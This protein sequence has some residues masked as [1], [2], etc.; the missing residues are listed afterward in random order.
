MLG[1]LR[2]ALDLLRVPEEVE[3][4][5][6]RSA[7]AWERYRETHADRVDTTDEARRAQTEEDRTDTVLIHQSLAYHEPVMAFGILGNHLAVE[8]DASLVCLLPNRLDRGATRAVSSYYYDDV[9]FLDAARWR[10]HRIARALADAIELYR[11]LDNVPDLQG[12][13]YRGIEIGDLVY[14]TALRRT[15]EGTLESI[16]AG[17]FRYVFSAVRWLRCFEAVFDAHRPLALVTGDVKYTPSGV[18]A[19]LAVARD[20]D[21]FVPLSGMG[22]ARLQTLEDLRR[23]RM[24]AR[25]ETF[26][27]LFAERRSALVSRGEAYRRDRMADELTDADAHL[28][29][30]SE[31]ERLEPAALYE[32][33]NLDPANPTVAVMSHVFIDAPV[34]GTYNLFDDYLDWLRRTLAFSVDTPTVN[35][36]VKEHPATERYG[37]NQ[38]ASAEVE[39]ATAGREATTVY[40][41][42][43]HVH[44]ASVADFADAVVTVRGTAGLEFAS[45]GIPPILAGDSRYSG[46][47][48]THEPATRP[49][50]FERLSAVDELEALTAEQRERATSLLYLERVLMSPSSDLVPDWRTYDDQLAV[51]ADAGDRIAGID[52]REDGAYP[53]LE[54]FIRS[55]AKHT[56]DHRPLEDGESA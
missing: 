24:A 27:R 25:H 15:G 56:I 1:K 33:S 10:P 31:K 11:D 39:A 12:L 50:Y 54:R 4:F 28:A 30:G 16:D 32:R 20:A 46:F 6:E 42:P 14:N 48:F 26:E 53:V 49:A 44:T 37:C 34:Q 2:T 5:A 22:F 43:D 38:R 3:S 35:W 41:L 40:M 52:P 29:Y 7:P 45:L 18:P 8:H 47:G 9:H 19:R 21:V 55:E 23:N 36:I 51:W 13:T 17:V